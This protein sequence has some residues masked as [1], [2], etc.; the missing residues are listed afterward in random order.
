MMSKIES[1]KAK[2]TQDYIVAIAKALQCAPEAI[3]SASFISP[4][5]ASEFKTN[6]SGDAIRDF[7]LNSTLQAR[8]MFDSIYDDLRQD[9][10]AAAPPSEEASSG[11]F[12]D[13][14]QQPLEKKR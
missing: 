5:R 13:H 11:G 6:A 7:Y 2:L 12:N 8:R 4:P 14:P 10:M 3:I 9:T 1:G